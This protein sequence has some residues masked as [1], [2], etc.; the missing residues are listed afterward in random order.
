MPDP[1][2][3]KSVDDSTEQQES[4]QERGAE[5]RARDRS[6]T[7]AGRSARDL[8][9]A[10][11]GSVPG[12]DVVSSGNN[13]AT[14]RGAVTERA[15]TSRSEAAGNAINRYGE[16]NLGGRNPSQPQTS[17]GSQDARGHTTSQEEIQTTDPM[18]SRDPS[19]IAHQTPHADDES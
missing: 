10:G 18:T 4:D 13:P 11:G 12:G 2:N 16:G 19:K 15:E 14:G 7:S 6:T 5:L 17:M 1:E 9:T 3:D 8:G